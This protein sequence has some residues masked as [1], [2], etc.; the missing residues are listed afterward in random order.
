MEQIK[1]PKCGG[2]IY[3]TVYSNG[4][5]CIYAH[6]ECICGFQGGTSR[7]FK[8]ETERVDREIRERFAIERRDAVKD[9]C[10]SII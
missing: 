5:P 8:G 7:V 1:C 9:F 10:S 4:G 6:L 3:K 2:S